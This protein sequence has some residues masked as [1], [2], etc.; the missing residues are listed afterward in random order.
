MDGLSIIAMGFRAASVLFG[1]IL[2]YLV[3]VIYRRTQGGSSGWLY[4]MIAYSSLGIWGLSQ[5]IFLAV[6]PSYAVRVLTGT[7]LFFL[8]GIMHPLAAVLLSRDMKLRV[9]SWFNKR[10]LFVVILLF[11]LSMMAY[12]FLFTSFT[13][14]LA[15]VLAITLFSVEVFFLVAAFGF[16][17]I[18][19]ETRVNF[20]VFMGLSS[21]VAALGVGMV[22][23]FTDCC[24]MD[25]PL[26]G[27][28]ACQTWIYDYA[29]TLPMPCVE[30]LLPLSSNGVL[31]ILL[32]EIFAVYAL[33]R[34][35]KAME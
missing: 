19:R 31:L 17:L 3:I 5:L 22:V 6:L 23:A 20:W 8:I 18:F 13:E 33:F 30:G 2:A 14:P 4:L 29:D 28:A 21:L 15:E 1:L 10:N 24:G 27:M 34:M 12:N 25:A 35:L 9:P 11:Y 26:Q 16:Y 7:M 32:G